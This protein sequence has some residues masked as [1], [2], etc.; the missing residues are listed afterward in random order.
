M[1]P[2]LVAGTIGAASALL[3]AVVGGGAALLVEGLR[4]KGNLRQSRRDA[5]LSACTEFTAAIARVKSRSQALVGN[6]G[7]SAAIQAAMEE[8]RVGC[9]RLRLLASDRAT[10]R[11]ARLTLRHAYAVWRL[12]ETGTDPR[13]SEYPETPPHARLRQSLS[14]LYVGV[15]K[16]LA[17]EHPEDVFE[18]LED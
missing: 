10:Q 14:D 4:A 17:V 13:L 2:E 8:A 15:R 7:D 9:E 18:E 12:A 11:A 3:G 1:E 6:P 5:L 16:E